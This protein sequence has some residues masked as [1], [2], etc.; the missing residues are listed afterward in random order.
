[1]EEPLNQEF[2]LATWKTP[3][4]P[5][6]QPEKTIRILPSQMDSKCQASRLTHLPS[7]ASG[8][9]LNQGET[10]KLLQNSFCRSFI[11]LYQTPQ[12]TAIESVGYRRSFK[13]GS[14]RRRRRPE[15]QLHICKRRPIRITAGHAEMFAAVIKVHP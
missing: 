14:Q 12:D 4:S 5:R 1:V 2:R 3:G 7:V 13:S 15:N 10:A 9:Q 6:G 8:K 11:Y